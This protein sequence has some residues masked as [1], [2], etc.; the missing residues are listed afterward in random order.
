MADNLSRIVDAGLTAFTDTGAASSTP[1]LDSAFVFETSGDV[2]GVHFVAPVGQSSATLTFYAYCTA[3]TGTPTF[4]MEVRN[5]YSGSGDVNR[6]ETT[7][8]DLAS[9]PNSVSPTANTWSTFTCTVSLT[10][11][12]TYWIVIKNTHATPAS[13]HAQWRYRAQL[14]SWVAGNQ[15]AFRGYYTLNGFTTDPTLSPVQGSG[16]VKFSDGTIVGNPYISSASHAS[17]SNSR[18][19]RFIFT[20]DVT[21]SGGQ[22]NATSS[23]L[24]AIMLYTGAGAT[25]ASRTASALDKA[26][27]TPVRWASVTL[28]GGTAYD[29]VTEYGS[30]TT[31]GT[32]YDMGE[33]EGSL[34][35]DVLAC[36]PYSCAHVTGATPGSFTVDNSKLIQHGLYLD[37]HPAI[38]GGGG[39]LIHPGMSGGMRG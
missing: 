2:F 35:A 25:V 31:T 33:A 30:A 14:D 18:G 28:T 3:V 24:S 12:S 15:S 17:N 19:M 39:I 29:F 32:V 7:G 20:E 10:V 11:G 26:L 9:S 5:E 21:C 8:S 37:D 27:T 22:H 13:N 23:A 1:S 6:P 36:R 34:P 4:E 16:V 38:A